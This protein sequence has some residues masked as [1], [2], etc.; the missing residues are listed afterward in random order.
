M[1]MRNLLCIASAVS[2]RSTSPTKLYPGPGPTRV[3][4]PRSPPPPEG[5]WL[6]TREPLGSTLVSALVTAYHLPQRT[7]STSAAVIPSSL[8]SLTFPGQQSRAPQPATRCTSAHQRISSGE[9]LRLTNEGLCQPK[10]P[11]RTCA[12]HCTCG[13][14]HVMSCAY[15]RCAFGVR[16]EGALAVPA[17][18]ATTHLL[19]RRPSLSRHGKRRRAVLPETHAVSLETWDT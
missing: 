18:A 3:Q 12:V 16:A 9:S 6:R 1:C 17:G 13:A 4:T 11:R 10:R 8:K 7:T 5:P 14:V 19:A 2:V 15:G